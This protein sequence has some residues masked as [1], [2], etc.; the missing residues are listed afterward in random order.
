M[1]HLLKKL[2]DDIGSVIS[3]IDNQGQRLT[4]IEVKVDLY[5]EA[6]HALVQKVED[7]DKDASEALSS[8]KSAHKRIDDIVASA[9]EKENDLKWLKRAFWTML[10]GII[11]G[12]ITMIIKLKL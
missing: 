11:S 9:K 6:Q 2:S 3:K 10:F 12:G 8:T 5:R 4:G 7:V 1:E